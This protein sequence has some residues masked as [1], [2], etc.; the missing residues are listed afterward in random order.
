MYKNCWIT[1]PLNSELTDEITRG[2]VDDTH[3]QVVSK[4]TKAEMRLVEKR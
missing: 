2:L 3:Q 4:L 1:L